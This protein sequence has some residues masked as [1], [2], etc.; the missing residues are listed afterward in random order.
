MSLSKS[1]EPISNA[2][3]ALPVCPERQRGRRRVHSSGERQGATFTL[4]VPVK[5]AEGHV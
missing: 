1:I 5:Y 3:H 4:N 2:I